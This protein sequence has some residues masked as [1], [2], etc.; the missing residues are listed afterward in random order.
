MTQGPY[1][2]IVGACS[3]LMK[4]D[5]EYKLFRM[6]EDGFSS[7]VDMSNM[8]GEINSAIYFYDPGPILVIVGFCSY[9]M[10]DD[11]EYKSFRML[12]KGISF[13][14]LARM[15]MELTAWAPSTMRASLWLSIC[16]GGSIL[17]PATFQQMWIPTSTLR[18]SL[19]SD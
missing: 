12:E 15:T 5:N 10:E 18:N 11:N 19:T 1:L 14:G 4:D 7:D 16:V 3:N 6:F 13:A 9:L 8:P 17:W 2:V